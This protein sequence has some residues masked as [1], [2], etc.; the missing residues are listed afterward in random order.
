MQPALAIT[1]SGATGMG[2]VPVQQ[3]QMQ[4]QQQQQQSIQGMVY[5][6]MLY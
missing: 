5:V 4:Q 1:N 2:G 6:Y 3:Q